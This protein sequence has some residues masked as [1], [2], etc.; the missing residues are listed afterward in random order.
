MAKRYAS[1]TD[2]LHS[3]DI[4]EEQKKRQEDYIKSRQLSRL[5]TVMR[6]QKKMS[7]IQA[8]EKLG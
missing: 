3:M 8:A 2:V 4:P 1:V 7:Q 6:S 5:L